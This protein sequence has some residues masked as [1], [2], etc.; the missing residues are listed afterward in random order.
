MSYKNYNDKEWGSLRSPYSLVSHKKP[1]I[2]KA[3][4]L[5][6]MLSPELERVVKF[7]DLDKR[8][9]TC[10]IRSEHMT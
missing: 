5:L 8:S 3:P 6:R 2:L 7:K 1:P 9:L 4:S 10:N